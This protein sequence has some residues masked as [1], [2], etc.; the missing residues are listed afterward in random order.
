MSLLL[1]LLPQS[2]H[3]LFGAQAAGIANPVNPL[4]SAVQLSEI[5]RVANTRVLVALGPVPGS[6]IWQKVQAIKGEL[7]DLKAILVAQGAADAPPAACSA[8]TSRSPST[9]PTG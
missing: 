3:A 7:P 5:L 1:P 6:D 9:R 2:F 8:S 4:L